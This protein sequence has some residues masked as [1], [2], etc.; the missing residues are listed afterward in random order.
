MIAALAF[1]PAPLP[2]APRIR[3]AR[4]V[5]RSTVPVGALCVV[6]NGV[7]EHLRRL[8]GV[9][10]DVTFGEAAA[11]TEALRAYL[12]RVEHCYLT[13]GRLS[14]VALFVGARDARRLLSAAFGE[15]DGPRALSPLERAALGRLANELAAVF[16][17]LC[18]ERYAG[19]HAVRAETVRCTSYVDVRI[20]PPLDAILG[21]GVTRDPPSDA[22]VVTLSPQAL[23]GLTC[24]VR[25]EIATGSLGAEAL[26][27][28]TVGALVRM[29]TKVGAD[30]VLKVGGKVVARGRAG[31]AISAD[32]TPR[33]AAFAVDSV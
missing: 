19:A 2:G 32:G 4:F 1:E 30:A 31:V 17:P 6:A 5:A 33:A 12:A 10:A 26:A 24:E 16:D 15:P 21:I 8:L 20:G 22:G 7:R 25:A 18:A 29:D 13:R 3:H 28:L 9:S 27:R 14:D 23:H 11:V